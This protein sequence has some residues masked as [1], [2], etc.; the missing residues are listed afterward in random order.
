MEWI[1]SAIEWLES[2]ALGGFAS[3]T[4]TG[5]RTRRYHALLLAATKPPTGRVVLVNG[6]EAWVDGAAGGFP[7]SSHRYSPD[8]TYP[9]GYRRIAAFT[10]TPWP[11]WIFRDHAGTEIEQEILVHRDT[12]ETVL[13]WR[14]LSKGPHCLR[15]RL[16]LSGRDYHALHRENSALDMRAVVRGGSVAWRPYPDLPTVAALTN[17]AY[18]HAPDWYRSFFY[19]REWERG[20]DCIEDLA[21]PGTFVWDLS[22][23]DAVMVLRAGDGLGVRSASYAATLVA[24]ERARRE[25][26]GPLGVAAESYLV[27]RGKGCTMIAGFPWF[28][29]WGRDTFIAMRGL[30]LATGRLAEAEAILLAWSNTVS[31]GMLPNRFPDDGDRPEYNAVDASLWFVVAIHEFLC[32]AGGK[33]VIV[34]T[35]SQR[36][37]QDAAEAILQGY[38]TGTRFAIAADADGLLRAGVPGIQ[39]TWMDAKIDDRPVTPRIGKPVEVQ[40]LWVNAL[41][42]GS[43]W[44]AR[45]AELARRAAASFVARFPNPT[46][47]LYDVIDADHVPG[48]VDG[49]MRPNQIL[50]VGGLP[51]PVLEGPA[52]RAVVNVVEEKLLTPLGLRTLAPDDPDYVPYYVGGPAERDRAY[53]QGAAWPWLAGP[54]V[55]AWLRVRCGS[56]EAKS[57]AR[58][59]FLPPLRAHLATAGIGHVS[60]LADGAPPHAPGGCP[61]QAWSLGELIRIERMLAPTR[62]EPARE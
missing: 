60:E 31:Q 55:D 20:L 45:W 30:T 1:D 37:L 43:A 15:V 34:R 17:G 39:L 40:A 32:A 41:C 47:G 35:E 11:R 2:D 26:A 56:A 14:Q 3:G 52:A 46:T 21:S 6:F 36:R 13:R 62:D 5:I 48:A 49:K 57:E 50:A 12:C 19:A 54:F 27:D 44:S 4:V 61:F 22:C 7:L 8:V 42:I 51:F 25:A 18:T 29:D 28:T 23:G 9:D 59:R 53:H 24:S 38:A 10:S 16:L 33:G 58:R